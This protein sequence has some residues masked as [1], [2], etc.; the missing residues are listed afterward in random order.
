M[1]QPHPSAP[2]LEPLA[3]PRPPLSTAGACELLIGAN[4]R[5]SI[6][7]E[8][9]SDQAALE[10]LARRRGFDLCNEGIVVVPI[11]GATNIGTFVGALGP[12]GLG[13]RLAVLCDAAEEA[14]T[15]RGLERAGLGANRA[16]AEQGRLGVC[17]ADLEDE[18]I[19]A[20]GPAAVERVLDAE[21]ELGSFR[22]FQSQPAQ[23]GRN[24]HVQ[25]RRFMGTRA[26][27]KIRYATLLVDA[28]DLDRVPTPLELVL[29][30]VMRRSG[31][32]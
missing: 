28:L 18:L 6:L 14:Y 19:H 23:R 26:R 3:G 4:A 27:R 11:G 31:E 29:A 10:T 7:V 30:Y 25:L 12:Q 16:G 20:L 13:V 8:G 15:R 2:A 22:R 1:I 21:G 24:L 17:H 32:P 9:W 5:A